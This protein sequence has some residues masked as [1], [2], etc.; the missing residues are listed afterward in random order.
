[1]TI[2]YLGLG[3]NIGDRV[4]YVQQALGLLKFSP[5]IR[6]IS[7]SSFYET[8]PVGFAEQEWFVNAAAAI[9]TTLSPE[10]LLKVCQRIESQLGRVRDPNNKNGPRTI[11]IDIL[12]FDT[13][14]LDDPGLTIPHP[15]L[16]ERAYALV[17]LLEINPRVHHPVLGKTVE[18]LHQSLETPEEVMLF[19]TRGLLQ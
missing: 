6:V 12:F 1:M 4:G 2:V 5:E 15:K 14:I 18:Q 10:A 9:D 16:H 13:I 11:D 8:E 17:P 19:G 3:S 7:T